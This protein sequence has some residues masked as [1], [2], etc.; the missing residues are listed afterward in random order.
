MAATLYQVSSGVQANAPVERRFF[1]AMAI[2]MLAVAAA[3]FLPALIQTGARRAPVSPLAAAHGA[4][5]FAWLI[6][7]LIQSRLI[8]NRQF[9]M[10]RRVGIVAS[11][12]LVLMVAFG[13]ETTVAMVRRGFD[14]SGDLR[15]DQDPASGATFPFT[16]IF[17]FGMLVV[18]ALAYRHRPDTHKS[19]MLF[20]NIVLMG[21]PLTH[22]IGHIPMLAALP[23]AIIMLPISVFLIA[24]VARD[25][26]LAKRVRVLTWGLAITLFL[27]GPVRAG[28]IAPSATWHRIVAWLV[29]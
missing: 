20:A 3:G 18:A 27:S 8:A 19:L 25:Y 21:A 17:L 7:Y 22:L 28:L 12:I 5:F 16:D 1:T 26:W 13:Y 15:I 9:A 24:A 14:L 4:L 23:G 2:A 6:I 10:H 29:R 11:L